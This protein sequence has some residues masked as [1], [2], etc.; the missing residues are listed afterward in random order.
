MRILALAA[1]ASLSLAPALGAAQGTCPANSVLQ[2]G[3]CVCADGFTLG[4]G[5]AC[6]TPQPDAIVAVDTGGVAEAGMFGNIPEEAIALGALA[7]LAA[8]GLGLALSD[9]DDATSTT[10]TTTTN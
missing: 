10:T 8:I 6:V 7:A 4:A 5:G 1:A 3:A 2:G 9:D